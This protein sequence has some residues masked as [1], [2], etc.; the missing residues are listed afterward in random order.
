MVKR[1]LRECD[2]FFIET[3]VDGMWT[4]ASIF[5]VELN[6][7]PHHMKHKVRKWPPVLE[8]VVKVV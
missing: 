6:D 4:I 2:R 7:F 5:E 3:E 8:H 1:K